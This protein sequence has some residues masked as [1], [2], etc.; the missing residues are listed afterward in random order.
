MISDPER[1][2]TPETY[3]A[4]V[5]MATFELTDDFSQSKYHH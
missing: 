4:H 5:H 2:F 3:R 1:Q